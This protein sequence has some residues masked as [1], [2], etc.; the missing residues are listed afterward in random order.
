M[1]DE[2]DPKKLLPYMPYKLLIEADGGPDHAFNLQNWCVLFALFLVSNVDKLVAVHGCPG[3]SYF[4]TVER[5]MSVLSIGT[6]DFA[7]SM[8]PEQWLL[9]E[10]LANMMSM[11]AVRKAVEEY[12]SEFHAVIAALQQKAHTTSSSPA[13][14]NEDDTRTISEAENNNDN[15]PDL[16]EQSMRKKIV[17]KQFKNSFL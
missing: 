5:T 11:K 10:V 13:N 14:T 7:A 6:N 2:M 4:N 12:D 3:L 15:N 17:K 9:D 8:K 1:A 16:S